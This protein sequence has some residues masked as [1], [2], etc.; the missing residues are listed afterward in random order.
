ML[1]QALALAVLLAFYAIYFTKALLQRRQGI[2]TRQIG[3]RKEKDLHTVETL[4]S[5]ATLCAPA[6]QMLSIAFSWSCL[7]AP[8]RL[9][10]FAIAL[11]G[12]AVFLTA[13]VT[14]KNSWRAGIP[15][16]DRTE[17]IQ[18]G[19]YRWSRNPA[20]LGF[21]LM[22]VGVCLMFCN[23]ATVVCSLFAMVTLHLQILQEE[24]Y[25]LVTFGAP[26]EAYRRSVCRYL[27]R[28]A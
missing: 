28:K 2:Q 15:Q 23:P 1:Y 9:A 14:M 22:Y 10:G 13:V 5:V 7:P 27:G 6:A 11:L 19:I 12:D 20:F 25:L 3:K 16:S 24:K 18:N 21:D 8:A 26:Y 4:M 17:L